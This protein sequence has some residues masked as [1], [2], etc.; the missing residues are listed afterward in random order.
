[1][2]R[3]SKFHNW[4][5]IIPLAILLIGLLTIV[6]IQQSKGAS[7]SVKVLLAYKAQASVTLNGAVAPGEW[8]DTPLINEPISGMTVAFKQNTTG[9]L[10]LMEW[11]TNSGTCSD[12]YCYGGIEIGFLNNTAEMGSTLTP[13]I[14]ILASPNSKGGVDEFISTGDVTPIT[15]ESDGYKTQST[16]G[17]ALS[18]TTYTA[19]CYRPFKLYGASPYDP[20]PILAAGSPI[21]IGFAVGDFSQPGVHSATDMSTYE[22]LTSSQTTTVTTTSATSSSG[23]TST[24]RSSTVSGSS[25]ST[26]GTSPTSSVT[27]TTGNVST[28]SSSVTTSSQP[29]ISTASTLINGATST[30]RQVQVANY[31]AEELLVIVAG[32]SALA[33][34]VLRKYES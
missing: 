14:M 27:A 6:P 23:S 12:K 9:L 20:F 17:L 15:V 7:E 22:L 21:E 18:G 34:L 31:Y 8:S 28:T 32:F 29:S 1:M 24:S 10:F 2:P 25:T 5:F 13:T 11:Q 33:V 19:E 3:R 16:C 26:T 30:T 4:R